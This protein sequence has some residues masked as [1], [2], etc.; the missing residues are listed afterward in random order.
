MTWLHDVSYLFGGAFL[1]NAVPHL[2]SGVR[3]EPFQTPLPSRPA[4][5]CR[6]R[7]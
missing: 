5:A 1:V 6:R 4:K 3:G 7:R 2:V